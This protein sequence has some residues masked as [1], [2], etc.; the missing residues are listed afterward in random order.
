MILWN[1]ALAYKFDGVRAF[2][3]SNALREATNFVLE[4]ECPHVLISL[5]FDE[6]SILEQFASGV[7]DDGA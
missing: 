3:V 7:V 5:Q 1:F 6:V 2:D 4:G